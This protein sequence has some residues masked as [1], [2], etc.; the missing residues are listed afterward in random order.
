MSAIEIE[1]CISQEFAF[2]L[3]KYDCPLRHVLLESVR[4]CLDELDALD[5]THPIWAK[6]TVRSFS[7]LKDITYTRLPD[8]VDWKL[9][10]NADDEAAQWCNVA[11]D[12]KAGSRI[13]IEAWESLERCSPRWRSEWLLAQA[14]FNFYLFGPQRWLEQLKE[15]LVR[16]ERLEWSLQ[17]LR[18][19]AFAQGT[20]VRWLISEADGPPDGNEC[21]E[22][23]DLLANVEPKAAEPRRRRPSES[24]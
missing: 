3:Q 13:S 9:E 10:H 19:P 11:F 1:A 16:R 6:P 21:D 7:R 20:C 17:C 24:S 2:L 5:R 18:D 14:F 4:S 15:Y 22:L 8:I 12:L 23:A